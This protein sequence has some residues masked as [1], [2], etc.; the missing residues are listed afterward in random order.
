[1]KFC[2]L[3]F[4][5]EEEWRKQFSRPNPRSRAG[6]RVL[7]ALPGAASPEIKQQWM[8]GGDPGTP[9]SPDI[10]LMRLRKP[11]DSEVL[12]LSGSLG[13]R[14]CQEGLSEAEGAIQLGIIQCLGKVHFQILYRAGHGQEPILGSRSSTSHQE[15]LGTH[16]EQDLRKIRDFLG[17]FHLVVFWRLLLW[18]KWEEGGP[19]NPAGRPPEGEEDLAKSSRG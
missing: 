12:T 17:V 15:G 9:F 16:G 19:C 5:L 3:L 13:A 6:W 14:M 10:V 8:H 4:F 11:A 2:Y 18:G 1:M 7:L